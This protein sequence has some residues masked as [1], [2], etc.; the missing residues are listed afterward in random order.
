MYDKF[1]DA[2]LTAEQSF[3]LGEIIQNGRLINI[4]DRTFLMAKVSPMMSD[5]LKAISLR[6]HQNNIGRSAEFIQDIS[7]FAGEAIHEGDL[8]ITL[9]DLV[10]KFTKENVVGKAHS[11]QKHYSNIFATLQECLGPDR[12]IKTITREDLNEF[13]DIITHLPLHYPKRYE[14]LTIREAADFSKNNELPKK[15]NITVN[16]ML[17]RVSKLFKWAENE[18]LLD[19]NP[20]NDLKISRERSRPEFK[21]N[22]FSDSQ[23]NTIFNAPIYRGCV[24]DK[25]NFK[26][27]GSNFPRRSR[28]WVPL[29]A[30]YSGLRLNEICQMEISDIRKIAGIDCFVVTVNEIR[31]S[32]PKNV[33]T[34]AGERIVPIHN[35]LKKIGFMQYASEIAE[36]KEVRLFPDIK[37]D[38]TGTHAYGIRY[39]QTK[40]V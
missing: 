6:N 25:I 33:K 20:A 23:L 5:F 8:G 37:R 38:H 35:E 28:F 34:K 12:R 3:A 10:D 19:K 26:K 36:R 31:G 17:V 39:S 32:K 29:V 18:W 16:F 30:L 21:R 27:P 7:L 13:K 15:N 22:P 2:P 4:D 1:V 24:D 40:A 9:C 11:T 14:N